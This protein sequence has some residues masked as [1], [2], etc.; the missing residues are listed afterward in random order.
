MDGGDDWAST[1]Q[2]NTYEGAD[3]ITTTSLRV[4]LI[5]G[6]SIISILGRNSYSS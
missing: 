6:V 2:P 4:D 5:L 3:T 1:K